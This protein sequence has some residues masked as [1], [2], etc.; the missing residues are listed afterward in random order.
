M[1][2]SVIFIMIMNQHFFQQ[3]DFFQRKKSLHIEIHYDSYREKKEEIK[4]N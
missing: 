2:Y 1:F 4:K 3:E